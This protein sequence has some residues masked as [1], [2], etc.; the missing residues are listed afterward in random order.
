MGCCISNSPADLPSE[1]TS[2]PRVLHRRFCFTCGFCRQWF[3]CRINRAKIISVADERW[4]KCWIKAI[5][6]TANVMARTQAA[7]AGADEAVFVDENGI[8]AECTSSNIFVV[9]NGVL[10]THPVGARVLPGVTRDVLLNARG[11][12]LK[13]KNAPFIWTKRR[14]PKKFLSQA[15]LDR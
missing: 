13:S 5:G 11:A 9:I 1:L 14:M 4:R 3:S 12:R 10:V 2:C 6:L 15:R 8:V 7:D